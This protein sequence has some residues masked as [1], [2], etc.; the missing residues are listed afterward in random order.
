MYLAILQ[1]IG[2]T[3]YI[4]SFKTKIELNINDM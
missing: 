1:L 2:D 4:V 3:I